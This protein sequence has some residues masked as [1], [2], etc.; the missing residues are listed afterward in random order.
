MS[1][2]PTQQYFEVPE[3]SEAFFWIR[4]VDL[5]GFP[6]QARFA[7][8]AY[9]KAKYFREYRASE[10]QD[11]AVRASIV[12]ASVYSASRA[13][14]FAA[15]LS[16]KGY[17]LTTFNR[18]VD[19]RIMRDGRII[20]RS[21]NNGEMNGGVDFK[22]TPLDLENRIF[23]RQALDAMS[24]EDKWAWES[25]MAGYSVRE[26]AGELGISPD[27]LSARLKRS[28]QEARKGLLDLDPKGN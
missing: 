16:A 15:V 22:A 18:L 6:V 14:S 3:A 10:L 13:H 26:L 28:L 11:S 7:D 8:A 4:K 23:C 27:A 9:K 5:E 12:E 21:P 24:P 17:L 20:Y 19:K 1:I 25:R 2:D